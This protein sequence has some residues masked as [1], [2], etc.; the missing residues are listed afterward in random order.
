M[1]GV[2][3]KGKKEIEKAMGKI[4]A[5]NHKRCIENCEL[6]WKGLFDNLK[7]FESE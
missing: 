2:T 7:E 1:R 6:S 4:K 3:E 5:E